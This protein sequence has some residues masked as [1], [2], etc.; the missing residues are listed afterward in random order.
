[1]SNL[2][3]INATSKQFEA[4]ESL[5]IICCMRLYISCCLQTC[6]V[7]GSEV[8]VADTCVKSYCHQCYK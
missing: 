3:V 4:K 1:M 2:I 5:I 8:M 6:N 7:A